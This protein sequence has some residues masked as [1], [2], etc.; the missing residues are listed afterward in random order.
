MIAWTL[1]GRV[2]VLTC[3]TTLMLPVMGAD[4]LAAC[5]QKCERNCPTWITCTCVSAGVGCGTGCTCQNVSGKSGVVSWKDC[6]CKEAPA[7][8][9]GETVGVGGSWGATVTAGA[10][11]PSS[12][13]TFTLQWNPNRELEVFDHI[14][15]VDLGPLGFEPSVSH[16]LSLPSDLTG[17]FQLSFGSGPPDQIPV[18]IVQLNLSAGSVPYLGVETGPSTIGPGPM[19]GSVQGVYNSMTGTIQFD[20]PVPAMATNSLFSGKE[21]FLRPVLA[22][23][24]PAYDVFVS[25][26]AEFDVSVPTI[27]EWGIVV[28]GLILLG[29]ATVVVRRQTA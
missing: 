21:I 10:V 6:L 13:A 2:K 3:V 15:L 16:F 1:S 4:V 28:M 5:T 8:S 11:A 24:G 23:N 29:A 17:T 7:S 27:S 20:E 14:H 25:G 26:F 22:L 18:Q 9:A 12:S 19:T